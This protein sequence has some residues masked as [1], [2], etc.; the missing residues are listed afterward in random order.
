VREGKKEKSEGERGGDIL[1]LLPLEKRGGRR[2]GIWAMRGG[3][4][5]G[6]GETRLLLF[7]IKRATQKTVCVRVYG[8]TSG[9]PTI[10]KAADESV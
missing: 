2:E 6:G 3:K 9:D 5:E 7:R 1:G 4:R 10:P 8:V